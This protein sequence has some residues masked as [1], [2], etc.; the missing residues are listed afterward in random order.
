MLVGF[1]LWGC[2]LWL[3]GS[4]VVLNAL[5]PLVSQMPIERE[6]GIA[7]TIVY[8]LRASRA[9][10]SSVADKDFAMCIATLSTFGSFLPV[11]SNVC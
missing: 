8:A 10:P 3:F 6:G 9:P 5:S 7:S 11:V 2:G 4:E 1:E